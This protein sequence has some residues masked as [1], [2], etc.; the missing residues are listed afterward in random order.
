MQI[1]V[2]SHQAGLH[3]GLYMGLRM[4]LHMGH[5]MALHMGQTAMDMEMDIMDQLVV[6]QTAT[7]I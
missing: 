4:E 3:M 6:C 2:V 7:D 5:P 1:L